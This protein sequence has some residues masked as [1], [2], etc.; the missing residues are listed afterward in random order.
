MQSMT[1]LLLKLPRNTE[2]TPEAAQTFLSTLTQIN[3]VS[4]LKK[5]MGTKSQALALEIV[6]FNQQIR[7]QIT[8]DSDLV[9]FVKTQIQSNY[10]LVIIEQT[11]DPLI[12]KNLE[13][14]KLFLSKGSYYPLATFESF[15]LK[16][17]RKMKMVLIPQDRTQIS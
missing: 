12:D 15:L 2:V 8:C 11:Q 9:P 17:A 6:L 16:E 5:L 3:S 13:I 14:K 7:F 10:P 1:T 4:S